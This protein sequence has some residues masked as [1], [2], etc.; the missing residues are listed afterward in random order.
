MSS[1]IQFPITFSLA[2]LP[3]GQS[4]D[5]NQYGQLLVSNL[6]AFISGQFLA[7][8]IDGAPPT[9]N[10]GVWFSGGIWYYW[11]PGTSTYIPQTLTSSFPTGA[12]LDYAG[13][14][15]PTGFVLCNGALYLRTG[16]MANLFAVIG[17]QY[18][19]GDGSST[20]GVPDTRGRTRVGAGQG[21]GL[22]NR[23]LAGTVGVE[24]QPL[25][26]ANLPAHAHPVPDPGHSHT[27]SAFSNTVQGLQAGGATYFL[28]STVSTSFSA[29]GIT[30]TSN[31]GSGTSHNNMQPS[32]FFNQIIK[33]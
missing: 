6:Q 16:A 10:I 3:T 8:Q 4:M 30:S 28:P 27:V 22:T 13:T 25:T 14:V 2:P 31:T 26:T 7:G 32:I 9:T 11:D 21:V 33:V 20:F 5:A 15:A 19:I 17:T 12:I 18:N 29:T 24:I 23:A 1:S